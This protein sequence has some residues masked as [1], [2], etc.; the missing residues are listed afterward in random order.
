MEDEG[1]HLVQHFSPFNAQA[2]A[3]DPPPVGVEYGQLMENIQIAVF[4]EDY[5]EADKAMNK[6]T[7]YPDVYLKPLLENLVIVDLAKRQ[8]NKEKPDL[9]RVSR[10]IPIFV[11]S[12]LRYF[13]ISNAQFSF[14]PSYIKFASSQDVV[15]MFQDL[16][17]TIEE[18]KNVVIWLYETDLVYSAIQN[19]YQA[20]ETKDFETISGIFEILYHMSTEEIFLAP[21]ATHKR[22]EIF[23]KF[24]EG[25]PVYAYNNQMRFLV[26]I[27]C[28]QTLPYFSDLAGF[29]QQCSR[30]EYNIVPEMTDLAIK[31]ITAIIRTDQEFAGMFNMDELI[32][33]TLTSI[34]D[35]PQHSIVVNSALEFLYEANK[36]PQEDTDIIGTFLDVLVQVMDEGRVASRPYVIAGLIEFAKQD[37]E[38]PENFDELYE[39][40]AVPYLSILEQGYGGSIPI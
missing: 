1:L 40:F 2:F 15:L 10:L 3:G 28:P 17:R 18:A 36:L 7:V 25:Q 35:Y 21:L 6:I 16:I 14:L 39:E 11:T 23:F 27:V 31:I 24:I 26:N 34:L 29:L 30:I 33:E 4:S 19:L 22:A 38:K 13:D 32:L 5:G 8:L 20:Q 37:C 12:L 9:I